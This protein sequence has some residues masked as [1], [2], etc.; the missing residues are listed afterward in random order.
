L[1]VNTNAESSP[2]T[3]NIYPI[4]NEDG[5]L[6]VEL[7]Y[8]EA[9]SSDE[10]ILLKWRTESEIY[11]SHW[12]IE[13]RT[14]YEESYTSIGT[15]RGQGN[16][17]SSTEYTYIDSTVTSGVLYYYMI[18][19]IS[20]DGAVTYH[21]PIS[22]L[23]KGELLPEGFSLGQNYPNPFNIQTVMSYT[24]PVESWVK[25]EIYNV[26][27]QLVSTLVDGK[28]NPGYYNVI[29]DGTDTRGN[30]AASGTHFCTMMAGL[31][32]EII[33]RGQRKM[34]ILK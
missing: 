27:G 23:S 19:D 3:S 11:N 1:S 26:L 32:D 25:I 21:G 33:L 14:E 34:L 7:A 2:V 5:S 15:L 31:G 29:W 24:V 28:M 9:S 30:T 16:K 17:S 13:R 4:Y 6:P 8:L 10:Q 12:I 18:A 20:F 22:A